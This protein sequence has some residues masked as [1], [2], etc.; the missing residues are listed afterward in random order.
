MTLESMNLNREALEA[1]RAGNS[2]IGAQV[3]AMGGVDAVA[4]VMD[5]VEENVQDVEEIQNELART[6]AVP[7]LEDE[8][9][10]LAELE[11]LEQEVVVG[12]MTEIKAGDMKAWPDAPESDDKAQMFPAAGTGK[13][14]SEEERELAE[15]EASM[16]GMQVPG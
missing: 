15:L 5:Q 16:N 3:Q 13:V 11:A 9:D 4:E 6:V 14:M 1:Q 8:D 12:D 7:G 10:L 2:A